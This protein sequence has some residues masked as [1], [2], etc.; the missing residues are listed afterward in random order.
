MR[1]GIGKGTGFNS[2]FP[3]SRYL[4]T[5]SVWRCCNDTAF[6]V[7]E[8]SEIWTL[9]RHKKCGVK[10]F[11][12]SHCDKKFGFFLT[13]F[14]EIWRNEDTKSMVSK[15]FIALIAIRNLVSLQ[16]FGNLKTWRHKKYGVKTFSCSPELFVTHLTMKKRPKRFVS[17]QLFHVISNGFPSNSL[18]QTSKPIPQTDFIAGIHSCYFRK[19]PIFINW[20]V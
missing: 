14:S 11:Y 5:E 8:I 10:T 18:Q 19:K 1:D 16:D 3:Q 6:F 4:K 9:S 2:K 12:C 15:L 20:L 17:S 7:T 13:G